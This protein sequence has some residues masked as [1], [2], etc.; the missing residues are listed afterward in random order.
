MSQYYHFKKGQIAANEKTTASIK[1][2]VSGG[3]GVIGGGGGGG[4]GGRGI[5]F[6]SW[7]RVLVSGSWSA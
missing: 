7:A 5:P 1:D 6:M 2:K 4:R 3:G